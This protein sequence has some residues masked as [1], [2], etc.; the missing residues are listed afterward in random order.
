MFFEAKLNILLFGYDYKINYLYKNVNQSGIM[1][2]LRNLLLRF[3]GS[4]NPD[5]HILQTYL[6]SIINPKHMTSQDI[7]ETG[8]ESEKFFTFHNCLYK[9][10]HTR[11]VNLFEVKPL[12]ILYNYFYNHSSMTEIIRSEP[13]VNKNFEIYISA[14]KQI[15]I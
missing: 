3:F 14:V 15:E 10:S 12:A 7:K 9:Y 13:S 5:L 6:A 8:L 4:A 1:N 11:L 2:M